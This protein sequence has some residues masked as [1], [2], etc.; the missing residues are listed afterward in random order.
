M[1]V[2]EVGVVEQVD[3]PVD[4]CVVERHGYSGLA[5]HRLYDAVR[6]STCFHRV[7]TGTSTKTCRALLWEMYVIET[8]ER[9]SILF[10]NT[11][12]I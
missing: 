7:S 5:L 8:Y 2:E 11:D 12:C 10:W 4:L 3:T 9:Y 6:Q 1:S